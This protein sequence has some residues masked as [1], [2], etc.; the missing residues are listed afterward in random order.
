MLMDPISTTSDAIVWTLDR[1]LGWLLLLPRDATLLVFALMTALLMTLVR[2]WVTNQDLLRRCANDLRQ[3]KELNR[4][5][6]R[7]RDKPRRQRLRNTVAMI[8]QI[9][10]AEDMKVLAVVLLPVALLAMWAVERLDYLPPRVGDDVVVR[11][12]FPV[13]SVDE[14]THLVPRDG[15]EFSSP[16]VQ[17]IQPEHQSPPIGQAEW[18][19]RFGSAAHGLMLTVRHHGDSAAHLVAVGQSTY[20]P[21]QQHHSNERLKT[22]EV[23]LKRYQP[24]GLNLKTE[25]FGLPP[26]MISY[27]VLTLLL[28]PGLKRLLRVW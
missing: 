13:S 22:T 28:V 8:K 26:W 9:Q 11:A 4:E 17:I 6:K 10:L 20:L 12:F 18:R 23:V 7:G 5:A 24:L 27:L 3:L 1:L 25:S 2:R 21:P 16:A 14:L 15:V 19:L